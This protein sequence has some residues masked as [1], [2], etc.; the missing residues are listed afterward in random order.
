M[1]I[2]MDLQK[3]IHSLID[4]LVEKP[5]NIVIKELPNNSKKDITVI[6]TADDEDC[7]RLIGKHG[8]VANALREAVGICGKA[9]NSNI[10]VHLRFESFNDSKN[11]GAE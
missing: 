3:I 2:S 8:S 7:A 6:I 1:Q 9:D 11:D 5:E 10:R 4:P